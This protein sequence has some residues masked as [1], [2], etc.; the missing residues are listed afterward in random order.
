MSIVVGFGPDDRSTSGLKLASSLALAAGTPLVLCC[1]IHNAWETPGMRDAASIDGEWRAQLQRMGA[2]AIG[3]ARHALLDG[4]EAETVLRSGRSVPQSLREEGERR[5]ADLLVMGPAAVGNVGRI[6]LGSTTSRLLH[7]S[8]IPVALAPRGYPGTDAP[9]RLVLAME[10]SHADRELV[11]A[12]ATQARLL[13]VPVQIVTYLVRSTTA[14]GQA[15]AGGDVVRRWLDL[16][17]ESQEEVAG[18]LSTLGVEVE[19]VSVVEGDRW[20]STLQAQDWDGGDILVV[21]SSAHG[22]VASVFLGSTAARII[23]HSPVPVV[24]LPR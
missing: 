8:S 7:G 3:T 19:S 18:R 1:V 13:G 4:V 9:A 2:E 12:V 16:V 11:E 15:F 20:S 5:G 14:A 17:R 24:V 6:A 22:P 10:P 21:G 23:R